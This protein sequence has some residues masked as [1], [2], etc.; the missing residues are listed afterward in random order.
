MKVYLLLM[1]MTD[2]KGNVID[3][4]TFGVYS[5]YKKAEEAK[6]WRKRDDGLYQGCQ[7]W[8]VYNSCVIDSRIIDYNLPLKEEQSNL[9]DWQKEIMFSEGHTW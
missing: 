6:A 9:R 1:Q 5:S 2:E 7:P 4:D 3:Y 8:N